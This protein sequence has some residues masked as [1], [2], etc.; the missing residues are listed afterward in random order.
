MAVASINWIFPPTAFLLLIRQNPDEC[1]NPCVVEH[2]L[3]QCDDSLNQVI[4]N[5][6]A[7]GIAFPAASVP[8]KNGRAVMYLSNAAA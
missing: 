3:R 7:A 1:P 4:L 8:R 6:I 5:Q 2:I